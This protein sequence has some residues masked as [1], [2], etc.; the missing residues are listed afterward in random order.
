MK[1]K[2][3]YSLNL[4]QFVYR[5]IKNNFPKLVI[6]IV[7][8]CAL[9]NVYILRPPIC[10][11]M[12]CCSVSTCGRKLWIANRIF[13]EQLSRQLI[14][15]FIVAFSAVFGIRTIKNRFFLSDEATP[16]RGMGF[17]LSVP[18]LLNDMEEIFQ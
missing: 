11:G 5:F 2:N 4:F 16:Y 10:C 15:D 13:L 6:C 18:Q 12:R 1:V 8:E 9:N 17:P 14:T 3:L 7:W